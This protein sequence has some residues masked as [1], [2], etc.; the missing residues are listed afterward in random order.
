MQN[1]KQNF[2]IL[3]FYDL[4]L[5]RITELVYPN[6]YMSC[7]MYDCKDP[8]LWS[9]YADNHKGVCLKFRTQLM[10]DNNECLPLYT[11]TI[12]G[13][14]GYSEKDYAK[15]IFNKVKYQKQHPQINFFQSLGTIPLGKLEKYW[16]SNENGNISKFKLFGG[17]NIDDWR[18][19][20]WEMHNTYLTIKSPEW[21]KENEYRIILS[22]HFGSYE[23]SSERKLKYKFEDLEA[24]I[25][26]CKTNI[27]D[28][29]KIM[30]IIDN[31]CQE[32]GRNDFKFFQSGFSLNG[33]F[34]INELNM[35]KINVTSKPDLLQTRGTP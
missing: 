12:I 9:F 4:F 3:D 6:A 21:K 13:S 22:D 34:E 11:K 8:S 24:I 16:F 26:G 15:F 25:F 32:I 30:N 5:K 17:E 27:N 19:K 23:D 35:L 20:Y 28:K 29:I 31:K 14:N 2:I 10:A 7:F 18:K 33:D 1:D